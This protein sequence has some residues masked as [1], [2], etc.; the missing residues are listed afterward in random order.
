MKS[1]GVRSEILLREAI[2]EIIRE[3]EDLETKLSPHKKGEE[4]VISANDD[5]YM[6]KIEDTLIDM[7]K[8]SYAALGGLKQVETPEGLKSKFTNF[9]VSDVDDDPDP[10]AGIYYTQRGGSRKAS[11]TTT[12]GT[13][14]GKAKVREMMTHFFSTPG[15][16]A[17]VS[18]APANIMIS[19]LGLPTVENEEEIRALL[20]RIPPEDIVFEGKHP[21]PSISYGYG[22]YTRTIR[23]HRET[24]IIVGNP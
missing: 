2:K 16:W 8:N 17:E 11:A 9:Y 6:T 21:D 18:G 7:F 3:E 13:P 23:G 1:A 14:A 12:D 20:G 24:K 19:K 10:D 5:D 15:S 22:W 4:V